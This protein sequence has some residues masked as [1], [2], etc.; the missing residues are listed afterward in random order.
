MGSSKYELNR[1]QLDK[2]YQDQT[3]F[4]KMLKEDWSKMTLQPKEL[5]FYL[6]QPEYYTKVMEIYKQANYQFPFTD[7]GLRAAALVFTSNLKE[8]L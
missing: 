4:F 6:V 2:D 5:Y 1:K 8:N 7:G 3:N